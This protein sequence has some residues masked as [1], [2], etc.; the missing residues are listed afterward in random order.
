MGKQLEKGHTLSDNNIQKEPT[1]PW[2]PPLQGASS[3]L[4]HQLAQKYNCHRVIRHKGYTRLNP[5][6]PT[7]ART[8]CHTNSLHPEKK[9]K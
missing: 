5:M 6:L 7:A 8:I 1:L 9:V 2:S 4:L 3:S